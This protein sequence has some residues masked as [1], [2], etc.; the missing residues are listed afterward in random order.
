MDLNSNIPLCEK[1]WQLLNKNKKVKL[2]TV[3]D[4]N[5][6]DPLSIATTLMGRGGHYSFPSISPLYPRYVPHISEC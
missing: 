3:V 1:K 2:A 6:K 4:G 5:Q